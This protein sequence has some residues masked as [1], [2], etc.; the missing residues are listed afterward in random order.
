M[1]VAD[2][3]FENKGKIMKKFVKWLSVA[4]AAAIIFGAGYGLG[5]MR[6]EREAV[7]P[8]E[9]ESE[10]TEECTLPEQEDIVQTVISSMTLR[11]MV[12]QMM[13]VTPEKITG[14][15]NVTKAGEA[16]K[17]A[18]EKYPVGGIVYFSNNLINR[19]QTEEMIKNTQ[20]YSKIPLFIGVDEEGGRVARLGKNPAMGTTLLPAMR[21]IG[22]KN[23]SAK[24]Y[25]AGVTLARDLKS[26]GFNVD[27]AP[28]ADVIVNEKN[29]EIGD[30]SFGTDAENVS[31]MVKKLTEGLEEN[32]VSATLKHFPGHGS[33]YANTHTGYSESKRTLDELK[34]CELLPFK[35]GI[36]AGADFVMVSH[37]TLV[38]ATEEKVPCSVSKEIITGILTDYLGYEGIIITD[39]FAM[40]AITDKYTPGEAAV[41]AVMA[42]ADMIL[43]SPDVAASCD[44]IVKAVENGTIPM[45]RIE[46]SV[47]K[48]L[49][50]KKEKQMLANW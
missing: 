32:G 36:E 9:A 39:S 3:L 27:F 43:M 49:T 1:S 8:T 14:I 30:R 12:Y 35:A 22:D 6:I 44:A 5:K 48:I 42:G 18:L 45:E 46:K 15:K 33:T 41:K 21:T 26:L 50:L 20:S 7:E 34:E 29:S 28:V 16:T 19:S 23:D 17:K 2:T 31:E 25:E 24:A 4:I 40:G 10:P 13:F 47:R 38:N 37:M 11:D